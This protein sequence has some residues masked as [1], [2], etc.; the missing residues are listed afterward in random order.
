MVGM[1]WKTWSIIESETMKKN[2]M[3]AI[4][5]GEILN[6][7]LKPLGLTANVPAKPIGESPQPP[8]CH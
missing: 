2:G 3:R 1:M 8:V 6:E 4:P 7:E 5:A